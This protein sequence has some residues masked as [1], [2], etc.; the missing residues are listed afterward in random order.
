MLV[1]ASSEPARLLLS[2][3]SGRLSIGARVVKLAPLELHFLRLLQRRG[4]KLLRRSLACELLWGQ[5][6]A[7]YEKRLDVLVKRLRDKL[8]TD[9]DLIETV[10]GRGHRLRPPAAGGAHEPS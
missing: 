4:G 2:P 3:L 8:G 1:M 5:S 9:Q 10:K 7:I 6:G